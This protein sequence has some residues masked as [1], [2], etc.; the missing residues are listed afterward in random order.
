LNSPLVSAIILNFNGRDNIGD[1]LPRCLTAVLNSDYP[2][3]EVIFFDNG[4]TDDSLEF[5]KERFQANH[6]L[7]IVSY[8]ENCGFSAGNNL[9]VKHTQGKYL[10]LLNS[11]VEVKSNSI[12]EL[13][14]TMENDLTIG[15]AQSKILF[16]DDNHIQTVGNVL[17]LTLSTYLIGNYE[18]DVGQYEVPCEMTFSAG[19]SMIVRRSIVQKIGLF[20]PNYFFFHDD[21]DLGWRVRLAGFKVVSVP[22]SIVH[23]KGEGTSSHSFKENMDFFFTLTSR[24]GLFIKNFE[25]ASMLK[26]GALVFVNIGRDTLGILLGGD[27]RTPTRIATWT[28][29]NFRYNWRNRQVVQKQIRKVP[30]KQLL[31]AFIDSSIFILN[32]R[33]NLA[34]LTRNHEFEKDFEKHVNQI[35]TAYYRSHLVPF[36]TRSTQKSLDRALEKQS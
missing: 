17:D 33:K 13:V 16:L 25:F 9:A 35:T 4:S 11:D 28:F 30:D 36:L 23:H 14:N 1:I 26:Y 3:I 29:R 27:I 20:D 21:C 10:F 15:M 32:I 24:I 18:E 7:K 2:N 8:P 34:K 19:A 31:K 6:K 5:V 22:T 12:R